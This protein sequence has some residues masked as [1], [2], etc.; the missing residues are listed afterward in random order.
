MEFNEYKYNMNVKNLN[1]LI[2][3]EAHKRETKI[4]PIVIVGSLRDPSIFCRSR[5]GMSKLFR[6]FFY[7]S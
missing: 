6:E 2:I 1:Y 5:I 3:Q 4:T 7:R